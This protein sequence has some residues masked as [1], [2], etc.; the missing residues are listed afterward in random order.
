MNIVI[1]VIG[2]TLFNNLGVC[3]MLWRL[4]VPLETEPSWV[5]NVFFLNF[6]PTRPF[7]NARDSARADIMSNEPDNYSYFDSYAKYC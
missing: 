6:D 2:K 4:S 3:P 5:K 1:C 7:H